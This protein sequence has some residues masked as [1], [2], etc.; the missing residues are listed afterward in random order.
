MTGA[1]VRLRAEPLMEQAADHAGSE[2][3]GVDDGWREGLDRLLD[4]MIHEAEL[5]EVGVEI[6]AAEVLLAL[7]NRLGIIRWRTEHP[8]VASEKIEKPI[9][10]VGQPR[11]GTTI[12][13][14]LLAQDPALRPPLTWEVDNPVP[15][16]APESYSS[17]PRIAATDERLQFVEQ[18]MPGFSAIHPMGATLGQECVR[19]TTGQFR[20]MVFSTSYRIPSYYRWLMHEADHSSS[21]RYH[22]SYLQHLQSGVP[23]HWLLKSPAH[24]WTLDALLAEYPDATIVQ[25]HRDPL[26]VLASVTAM[27]RHLRSMATDSPQFTQI[28]QEY[29]EQILLG[30]QREM[31]LR[32]KGAL[33]AGQIVDIRFADFMSDQFGTI[34]KLYERLDRDFTPQVERRMR[35]FLTAHPSG[36]A[37]QYRFHQT[38]LDEH[39]LREE[40]AEYLERYGVPAEAVY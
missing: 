12:L 15:P 36:G 22:R 10:I 2:D 4:A 23:G 37:S 19:I 5:N 35:A 30:L 39:E 33:P 8:E 18:L 14:D 34:G 24:L 1:A 26:K 7:Q 17:D 28:A 9:F 29:R 20:T 13:Y 3:F 40:V 16:P 21:Y 25:T 11:T 27:A 38:G 32:D 6:A 31:E